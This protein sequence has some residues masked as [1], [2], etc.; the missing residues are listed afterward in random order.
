MACST[1]AVERV[2]FA[3]KPELYELLHS[4]W[5]AAPRRAFK[6]ECHAKQRTQPEPASYFR[7]ERVFDLDVL[8][9]AYEVRQLHCNTYYHL[10]H[11]LTQCHGQQAYERILDILQN[12]PHEYDQMFVYEADTW[13]HQPA[14][15]RREVVY[16]L[17]DDDEVDLTTETI[18]ID[19]E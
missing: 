12:P 1:E 7:F 19:L 18:V 16:L 6:H 17:D 2:A 13:E 11:H 8:V 14:P 4:D 10:L 9:T 3:H 5:T 15:P